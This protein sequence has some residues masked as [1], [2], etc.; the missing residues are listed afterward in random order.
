MSKVEPRRSMYWRPPAPC[1]ATSHHPR[2][3]AFTNVTPE[4][5]DAFLKQPWTA[6]LSTLDAKG[7]IHAVPVWYRWDGAAFRIITDRGSQKH[8][9]IERGGRAS[10]CVDERDGSFR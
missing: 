7:R 10:L 1:D 5:R 6:V 9:N 3:V 4:E 2:P 8:R